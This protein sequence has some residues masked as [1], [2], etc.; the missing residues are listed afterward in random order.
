M[1]SGLIKKDYCCS[2]FCCNNIFRKKFF[3]EKDYR[4]SRTYI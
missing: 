3:Y 2:K 1:A 4:F